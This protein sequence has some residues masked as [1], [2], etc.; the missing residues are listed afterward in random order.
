MKPIKR[1]THAVLIMDQSSAGLKYANE[2]AKNW[3]PV[4][5]R[6][7]TWRKSNDAFF[8]FFL[9]HWEG[10]RAGSMTARD[11]HHLLNDILPTLFQDQLMPPAQPG[12]GV[13]A[14]EAGRI[15]TEIERLKSAGLASSTHRN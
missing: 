4:E 15:W 2:L 14:N 12:F 5:E 10:G 11:I 9:E 3:A 8:V 6:L 1:E 13:A 7:T